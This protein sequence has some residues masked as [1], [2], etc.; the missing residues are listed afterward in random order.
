METSLESLK[1]PVVTVEPSVIKPEPESALRLVSFPKKT[2][3][4]S[5]LK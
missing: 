3:A 4:Q 2:L 5:K 1:P